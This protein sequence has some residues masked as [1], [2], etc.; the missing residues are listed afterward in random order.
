MGSGIPPIFI[1]K[2]PTSIEGGF[3]FRCCRRWGRP[4]KTPS[5]ELLTHGFMVDARGRKMSKSL[6]NTIEVSDILKQH[7]AD[8]CRWWVS[9]LSYTHDIKVDW[10]FFC[11]ASEE[12]RKIRNTIRFLLGNLKDF[13]PEHAVELSEQDRYS[14]DS[15][16]MQQLSEF[17]K[18]VH[19]DYAS[20]R[21]NLVSD[22]IF[23]FC[24][25]TLSAVYLAALKGSALL[26]SP[27]FPSAASSPD[28]HEP[29]SRCSDPGS[30]LRSW[31]LRRK[32]RGFTH[33]DHSED[34]GHSVHFTSLPDEFDF[35][36]DPGWTDVMT[37]RGEALRKL[38]EA[39]NPAWRQV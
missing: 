17:V 7:G 39:K 21:F 38:E 28:G 5:V 24:N 6:G 27:E 12:Y 37:L 35:E 1:W 13:R 10:E 23:N 14:I 16:A 32:K 34:S 2:V 33:H 22:A 29:G 25:Q 18:A 11:V 31:S 36:T 3:S 8:V 30:G 19:R 20:F 4:G 15:W 9:S 26:R